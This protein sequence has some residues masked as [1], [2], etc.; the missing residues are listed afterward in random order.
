MVDVDNV[1]LISLITIVSGVVT[2]LIRTCLKSK[3]DNIECLCLKIHRNIEEEVKEEMYELS[4]K[5]NID[6]I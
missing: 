5:K 6:N 1:T 2:L 3:C 4:T